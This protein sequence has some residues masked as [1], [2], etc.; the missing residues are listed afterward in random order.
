MEHVFKPKQCKR[1]HTASKEF[2]FDRPGEKVSFFAPAA[3][4]RNASKP[5]EGA[6]AP[7]EAREDTRRD[8]AGRNK[9]AVFCENAIRR[10]RTWYNHGEKRKQEGNVC[11]E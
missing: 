11:K 1:L 3:F 9:A 6:L 4:I 5:D 10:Q 8:A 7:L 2:C